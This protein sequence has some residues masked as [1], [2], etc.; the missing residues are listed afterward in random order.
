MIK[1]FK[2]IWYHY[3]GTAQSNA[4]KGN[5]EKQTLEAWLEDM[6][7]KCRSDA[8]CKLFH[9]RAAATG[10]AWSPTVDNWVWLQSVTIMRQNRVSTSATW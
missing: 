8:V 5:G 2:M 4:G 10:K 1:V 3:M 9:I 7:Q 6:H